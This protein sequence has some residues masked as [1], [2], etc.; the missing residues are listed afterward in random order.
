A[1]LSLNTADIYTLDGSD[2]GI[3]IELLAEGNNW[4]RVAGGLDSWGRDGAKDTTITLAE[5][6]NSGIWKGSA[7]LF[8]G[9]ETGLEVLEGELELWGLDGFENGTT[10]RDDFTSNTVSGNE[11]CATVLAM[12]SIAELTGQWLSPKRRGIVRTNSERSCSNSGHFM[13]V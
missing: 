11:T 3:E 4:G 5:G 12:G 13:G 1:S 7:G 8:E 9:L 10:G 6:I 2:I